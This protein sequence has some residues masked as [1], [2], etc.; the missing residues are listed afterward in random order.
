[1]IDL[2]TI[3]LVTIEGERYVALDVFVTRGI[4]EAAVA[5]RFFLHT[6]LTFMDEDLPADGVIVVSECP[7]ADLTKDQTLR[8]G[9]LAE[10]TALVPLTAAVWDALLAADGGEGDKIGVSAV[11]ELVLRDAAGG[12]RVLHQVTAASELDID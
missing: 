11:I 6:T 3:R 9:E 8:R 7:V 12:S 4:V 2:P 10:V 1:M 5:D